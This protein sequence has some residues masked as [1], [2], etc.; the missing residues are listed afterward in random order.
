MRMKKAFLSLLIAFAGS[1]AMAQTGV[2]SGTAYGHGQ[3]SLRCRQNL[4]LFSG[5]SKTKNYKDA[6]EPW[7]NAIKECPASSKNIY[8]YGA[9]ILRWKISQEQD[10]NK[11]KALLDDLMNMYDLRT[12]YFGNSRKYGPDYI[13]GKK[14]ADYVALGGDAVDYKQLYDWAKP[15]VDEAGKGAN[16]ELLYYFVA[17]SKNVAVK[18]SSKRETYIKDYL[19]AAEALDAQL[20]A[21]AG[22][23]KVTKR[24]EAYKSPID[25]EFASSGLAGCDMLKKIYTIEK[26]EKNK[27]NK[28]FL[29]QTC[30]LFQ[31]AGCD[32]PAYFTASRY[33]FAIE[34]SARAAMGLAGKAIQDHKYSEAKSYLT[35][36]VD[37]TDKVKEKVMCYELLATLSSKQGAASSARAYCN[38]A[39]ELN[40]KSGSSMITLATLLAGQAGNIYPSDKVK[41][42]A[43][44]FLVIDKLRHAA[45]IDPSVSS[46]AYKLI[47]QYKAYLPSAAD[48]FMHPDLK[49]GASFSVPGYGSTTIR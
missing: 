27:E 35:K 39:L 45:A 42:K 48:I 40:P 7:T 33:L 1:S 41:Q 26:I 22:N 18:D 16:A 2:A 8:I 37:L 4:S 28:N 15:V 9:K 31:N 49:K 21:A 3:D 5:F 11:R 47:A 13:M 17:A 36:A 14:A 46:R 30:N 43:V 29:A 32:A 44:Y 25:Q 10:A 19:S 12:K 38:K 24:I 20:E 6:Y 34:P 23:E